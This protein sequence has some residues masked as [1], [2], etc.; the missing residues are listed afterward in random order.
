MIPALYDPYTTPGDITG[1]RPWN[2]ALDS[3]PLGKRLH[4]TV[5]CEVTEVLNGQY[6]M[7]LTYPE[8]GEFAKD[9]Q[10]RS[11]IA[12]IPNATDYVQL[13]RIVSV[14]RKLGQNIAVTAN[15]YSYDLDGYPVEAFDETGATPIGPQEAINLMMSHCV[16]PLGNQQSYADFYVN[17][18]KT[19]PSFSSYSTRSSYHH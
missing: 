18:L 11:I 15:H 12:A 13:F 16:F 5:R 17:A 3:P 2:P 19:A 1:W 7:Q 9:L 14:D 6:N 10:P 4:E 8:K